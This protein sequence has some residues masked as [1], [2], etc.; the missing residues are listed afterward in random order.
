[1]RLQQQTKGSTLA[2][3]SILTKGK[4]STLWVPL[5]I[6][7]TEEVLEDSI[8]FFSSVFRKID[9]LWRCGHDTDLEKAGEITYLYAGVNLGT[10]LLCSEN[11]CPVMS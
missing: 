10:V 1:M 9:T 6:Q 2:L 4:K 8:Q 3:N 5:I 11:E 7:K